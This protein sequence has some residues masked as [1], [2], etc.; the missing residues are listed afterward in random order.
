[1]ETPLPTITKQ[2]ATRHAEAQKLVD[3]PRPLTPDEQDFVLEHWHEG[4]DVTHNL[5]AAWFTPIELAWEIRHMVEGPRILD[6]CA[7][8]G[9]LAR[10]RLDDPDPTDPVSEMV[11]VERNPAYVKVGRKTV[12]EATWI[13]ADVFD[14]AH[15]DL[16]QFDTVMS[17]P[18]FGYTQRTGNGPRYR[19]RRFEYHVIDIASDLA[20]TGVF[21]VPQIAAPFRYSGVPV[22]TFHGGDEELS[23]LCRRHRR[24]ACPRHG[25]G[26]LHP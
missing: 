9:R 15:T 26:H 22:T 14:L 1:M 25:T 19:G 11:C 8:T 2:D 3:A 7:G 13:C 5:D 12:P 6:L 16:G 10:A 24:G 4:A 18:P 23:A 21:I 17:N 20:R